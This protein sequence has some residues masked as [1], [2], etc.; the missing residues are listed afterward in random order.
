MVEC[1]NI[2]AKGIR[3]RTSKFTRAQGVLM[4]HASTSSS[5]SFSGGRKEGS[6]DFPSLDEN[7][8]LPD[9]NVSRDDSLCFYCSEGL[10]PSMEECE[11]LTNQS[12]D[13]I[14]PFHFVVLVLRHCSSI[15]K[16]SVL[17]NYGS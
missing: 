12:C 14:V 10:C 8:L 5:T 4:C 2:L 17:L 16:I 7:S 6:V 1:A 15:R 3:G 13:D 9:L 11:L